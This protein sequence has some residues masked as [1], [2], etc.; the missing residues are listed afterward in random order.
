M[1]ERDEE[2]DGIEALPPDRSSDISPGW[3]KKAIYGAIILS[4]IGFVFNNLPKI[5]DSFSNTAIVRQYLVEHSALMQGRVKDSFLSP[6]D[7]I[8]KQVDGQYIDPERDDILY[9]LRVFGNQHRSSI[10]C[11]PR[12]TELLLEPTAG[13]SATFRRKIKN[14]LAD[15]AVVG[16]ANLTAALDAA[17]LDLKRFAQDADNLGELILMTSGRNYCNPEADEHWLTVYSSRFE[18][19]L[20]T[21]IYPHLLVFNPEDDALCETFRSKNDVGCWSISDADDLAKAIRAI[22]GDFTD[23][24]LTGYYPLGLNTQGWELID[25]IAEELE[26]SGRLGTEASGFYAVFDELKKGE[27]RDIG[28]RARELD[29]AGTPIYFISDIDNR[30]YIFE[31][32]NI[33]QIGFALYLKFLMAVHLERYSYGSKIVEIDNGSDIFEELGIGVGD[34]LIYLN[35]VPLSKHI[36]IAELLSYYYDNHAELIYS[37]RVHGLNYKRFHVL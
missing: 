30:E 14:L 28:W 20:A 36:T 34:H 2:P 21:K 24:E 29:V 35:G 7:L 15:P 31:G 18:M 10:E 19:L 17:F 3:W 26:E 11:D 5:Y 12:D 33:G 8:E 25:S 13:S 32:R 4:A 9:G 1:R 23:E 37:D 27:N 16:K 22:H 6:F